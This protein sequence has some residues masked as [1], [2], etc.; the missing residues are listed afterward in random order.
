[1]QVSLHQTLTRLFSFVAH[2]LNCLVF[3]LHTQVVD[4]QTG[5][6]LGPNQTGEICF[7]G[8]SVGLGYLN[9]PEENSRAFRDG[10]F[11][12]GLYS[13][14]VSQSKPQRASQWQVLR[15]ETGQM[16]S[17]AQIHLSQN[18]S[19]SRAQPG[20]QLNKIV[21]FNFSRGNWT[22]HDRSTANHKRCFQGTWDT[23]MRRDTSLLWTD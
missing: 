11:H 6:L 12:M 22:A 17:G 16:L 23:T 20:N 18:M 10:W 8:P 14:F 4:V 13:T 19:R 3:F 7:K 2:N 5:E 15:G 21:P 9:N 1:M